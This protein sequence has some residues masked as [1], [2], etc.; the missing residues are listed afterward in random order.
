MSGTHWK[1]IGGLDSPGGIATHYVLLDGPG[2]QF[3]WE[4]RFSKSDCLWGPS[5]FLHN[6]YRVFTRGKA[7][8]AWCWLLM[9]FFRPVWGRVGDISPNPLCAYLDIPWGDLT[10]LYV[11]ILLSRCIYIFC[12][13]TH[14][15]KYQ[16]SNSLDKT[17]NVQCTY[18]VTLSCV[19]ATIVTIEKQ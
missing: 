18:N 1:P 15:R 14:V 16:T 13:N 9:P 3:P 17:D 5:S 10:Y 19:R 2:V 11:C 6:G 4:A 7:A 8:G 12:Q